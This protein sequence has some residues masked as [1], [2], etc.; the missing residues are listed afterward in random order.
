MDSSTRKFQDL[1]RYRPYLENKI[2]SLKEIR[3]KN[4]FPDEK[5]NQKI[6]RLTTIHGLLCDTQAPKKITLSTWDKFEEIIKKHKQQDR[7]D[8]TC[9][10]LDKLSKGHGES[11]GS[12]SSYGSISSHIDRSKKVFDDTP[13]SPSPPHSPAHSTS[14]HDSAPKVIPLERHSRF[15]PIQPMKIDTVTDFFRNRSPSPA[16]DVLKIVPI[17]RTNMKDIGPLDWDSDDECEV[18]PKPRPPIIVP[19]KPDVVTATKKAMDN[20]TSRDSQR[21]ETSR[22]DEI[23]PIKWDIEPINHSSQNIPTVPVNSLGGSRRLKTV[24]E[25]T[26]ILNLN[27]DLN[28]I[29]SSRH[30]PGLPISDEVMASPNP[31]F[32][33]KPPAPPLHE[34]PPSTFSPPKRDMPAPLTSKVPTTPSLLLNAPMT[35]SKM[36]ISLDDISEFLDDSSLKRSEGMAKHLPTGPR[37]ASRMAHVPNP[38]PGMLSPRS[39]NT[40]LT[41]HPEPRV[42]SD[43]R[44][45]PNSSDPRSYGVSPVINSDPRLASNQGDPRN[46]SVVPS[47]DPRSQSIAGARYA[48]NYERHKRITDSS[49]PPDYQRHQYNQEAI[50]TMVPPP[51]HG[52][53][54]SSAPASLTYGQQM[55]SSN[56]MGYDYWMGAPPQQ[57]QWNQHPRMQQQTTAQPYQMS[58][59]S[60]SWQHMQPHSMIN[61]DSRMGHSYSNQMP[62]NTGRNDS[63][64]QNVMSNNT[65]YGQNRSAGYQD[66]RPSY[67][68]PYEQHQ[69]QIRPSWNNR[70]NDSERFSGRPPFGRPGGPPNSWNKDI[71]R[72]NRDPRMFSDRDPRTRPDPPRPS[73]PPIPPKETP[74][75][76]KASEKDTHPNKS[77]PLPEKEVSKKRPDIGKTD[78]VKEKT[79]E[80]E[81]D[82]IKDKDKHKDKDKD[83]DKHKDK[84]KNKHGEKSKSK[85][86]SS[87]KPQLTDIYGT[88]DAK[89]AVKGSGLQK[90]KIPKKRPS[91]DA[92]DT[93]AAS[94]ENVEESDVLIT[95]D[96]SE[97]QSESSTSKKSSKS[98]AKEKTSKKDKHKNDVLDELTDIDKIDGLKELAAA[99]NLSSEDMAIIF[100]QMMT[101]LKKK[102]KPAIYLSDDE[103]EDSSDKQ[104]SET[105]KTSKKK[106]HSKKVIESSDESENEKK[107]EKNKE[108]KKK[109]TGAL[110]KIISDESEAEEKDNAGENEE[111]FADLLMENDVPNDDGND[112]PVTEQEPESEVVA[113][114]GEEEAATVATE[115]EKIVQ[116]PAKPKPKRRT[117]EL[118]ALQEDLKSSWICDGAMRATGSRMCSQRNK[119]LEQVQEKSTEDQPGISAATAKNIGKMKK[120]LPPKVKPGPKSKKAAALAT[121]VAIAASEASLTSCL[122]TSDSEDDDTPLSFRSENINA[123]GKSK[124][125]TSPKTAKKTRAKAVKVQPPPLFDSSSNDSF[126]LDASAVEPST[127]ISLHPETN[128]TEKTAKGRKT[129]KSKKK[130]TTD[131]AAESSSDESLVDTTAKSRESNEELLDNVMAELASNP[132]YSVAKKK[133]TK[134]KKSNWQMGIVSKKKKKK[135]PAAA[136]KS[137][138]VHGSTSDLSVTNENDLAA[139]DGALVSSKKTKNSLE[140]QDNA[141]ESEDPGWNTMSTTQD[142]EE[143]ISRVDPDALIG[144]TQS[145]GKHQCLL[146]RF[147]RKNIVHHYKIQHPKK[148][149]LISRLPAEESTLACEESMRLDLEN[150]DPPPDADIGRYICRFC[151]FMTKGVDI[152]ARESFYEHCTNHTG[153]YRF[154]CQQCNYEAVTKGSIR[155]HFYKECRKLSNMNL[156]EAIIET[157]IPVDNRIYGYI[158][159]HCN[160]L[161]LKKSNVEKHVRLWHT[162]INKDLDVKIMKI[163]MSISVK[164]EDVQIST[165]FVNTAVVKEIEPKIE[166]DPIE[167]SMQEEFQIEGDED[168]SAACD[169]SVPEKVY[170][171]PEDPDLNITLELVEHKPEKSSNLSAFVCPDEV[172]TKKE[173]EI[174]N[175]RKKKMQEIAQNIG[176]K[177]GEKETPKRLS[178]IDK[179]K[180]KIEETAMPIEEIE[181]TVPE[182]IEMDESPSMEES[183]D[184]LSIPEEKIG[185]PTVDAQ[186]E[187][188]K[189]QILE[190]TRPI[191]E[192]PENS[193]V[194]SGEKDDKASN[195]IKDPLAFVDESTGK[196]V[197]SEDDDSDPNVIPPLQYDSESDQSDHEITTPDVSSILQ[198]TNKIGSPSKG[199]MMTTIQRLAAQLQTK[200]PETP[201]LPEPEMVM[202]DV[203]NGASV[204]VKTEQTSP[205]KQDDMAVTSQ[206]TIK[207]EVHAELGSLTAND[208]G[209]KA[210]EEAASKQTA[211]SP[212]TFIRIRRISGDKLSKGGDQ[213]CESN[214]GTDQTMATMKPLDA[215][216]D[217]NFGFRIE[218]VV[219]L[220]PQDG[221]NKFVPNMRQTVETSPPI[222]GLPV[223]KKAPSQYII[224]RADGTSQVLTSSTGEPLKLVPISI[225]SAVRTSAKPSDSYVSIGGQISIK[226]DPKTMTSLSSAAPNAINSPTTTIVTSTGQPIKLVKINPPEQ[227]PV[228][229]KLKSAVVYER[230]LNDDKLVHLFKCMGRDCCFTTS[231]EPIF[232]RHIQMHEIESSSDVSSYTEYRDFHKCAYCYINCKN[233]TDLVQHLETTHIF[234]RYCCKYCFYRAYAYSYVEIHQKSY[235]PIKKIHILVASEELVLAPPPPKRLD[236][237]QI[238]KPYVCVHECNK[239]FFIPEAFMLHLNMHHKNII[240][241]YK[242]HICVV[243]ASNTDALIEH[244]KQH[245]YFKYH[246]LYCAHGAANM[247]ELASH[248]SSAH[249]NQ[250]PQVLERCLPREILK[251]LSAIEQLR[252]RDIEVM[253]RKPED[254]INPKVPIPPLSKTPS[255]I[256]VIPSA[257]IM[258]TKIL[259]P[260]EKLATNS[261][262]GISN[263]RIIS[264]RS[265]NANSTNLLKVGKNVKLALAEIPKLNLDEALLQKNHLSSYNLFYNKKQI[266]ADDSND[267]NNDVVFLEVRTQPS[268]SIKN[269]QEPTAN[270][271]EIKE[272]TSTEDDEDSNKASESEQNCSSN[273]TGT[274][275]STT[276]SKSGEPSTVRFL[277]LDDVKNTGFM[278]CDLFR[279]GV[280]NCQFSVESAEELRA[281]MQQCL[282]CAEEGTDAALYCPHCGPQSKRFVKPSSF[283][284]HIKIHGVKRFGCILCDAKFAL[285]SQA[286]CHLRLKHKYLTSRF[287][288]ADPTNPSTDGVFYIHPVTVDKV[289]GGKK[290]QKTVTEKPTEQEKTSFLPSEIDKLPLPAIFNKAVQCAICSYTNKVRTNIVR[291]LQAH[292]KDESVPTACPVNPVPCLDKKERMFDKMVNLASSS[293]ENGR[294][295]SGGLGPAPK[296]GKPEEDEGLPKFVPEN[297]R[298]VCGVAEC[299]YLSVDE[300]MLRHHLKALHSDE[301]YYRCPHC[302]PPNGQDPGQNIALDKMGVH[303]KMHDCR[304]YKCS[305]CIYHHYHR[306]VVERHLAD[307]HAEKRQFVKVVRELQTDQQIIENQQQQQLLGTASQEIE[308]EDQPDPDGN[309]W[310]CNLCDFKCILKAAIQN[311]AAIEHNERCQFK[312]NGCGFRTISKITF[313]Q[314]MATKHTNDPHVDYTTVYRRIKSL[315]KPEIVEAPVVQ[316]EPFDTTPLWSR[317]MPRIRH[318]RGILFEE[319]EENNETGKPAKRKSAKSLSDDPLKSPETKK[320][321]ALS[322]DD[323]DK[324]RTADGGFGSYGTPIGNQY[325][326]V[327]CNS[328]KS[329]YKQDFRDHMFRDLKYLRWN[330]PNCEYKSVNRAIL[331]KHHNSKHSGLTFNVEPTSPDAQIEDWVAM[332]VKTQ[333]EIMKANKAA[334][335]TAVEDEAEVEVEAE[336]EESGDEDDYLVDSIKI[337][338]EEIEDINIDNVSS[339]VL[340]EAIFCKHCHMKFTKWRGFKRHVQ[341][342]HLKRLKFLC[343]YC[344]RS[345]SSE[346]MI[347]QHVRSRHKNMPEKVV[348]NPNPKT[349]ELSA[350]FWEREYGLFVP[351]RSKKRKRPEDVTVGV[352]EDGQINELPCKKCDFTALNMTGLKNHMRTHETKVKQK[353]TYCTFSSFNLT[354]MRQHWEVN[355]AHLEF[356]VEEAIVTSAAMDVAALRV[357]KKAKF[358]DEKKSIVYYCYYCSM[359]SQSLDKIRHHWQLLHKDNTRTSM[360]KYKEHSEVKIKCAYCAENGTKSTLVHHIREKHGRDKPLLMVERE[361][362]GWMCDECKEFL[363]NKEEIDEHNNRVHPEYTINVKLVRRS[364]VC[365]QCG[366][367]TISADTMMRHAKSHLNAYRCKYCVEMFKSFHA[368]KNH[369]AVAHVDKEPETRTLTTDEQNRVIENLMRDSVVISPIQLSPVKVTNTPIKS[370]PTSPRLA[371]KSTTKQCVRRIWPTPDK[372]KAVARKS[373][374][375]LPRYPSGIVFEIGERPEPNPISYYGRPISPIDLSKFN[376][377]LNNAGL[378]IKLD[379]AKFAEFSNINFNPRLELVDCVKSITRS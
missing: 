89:K 270:T 53:G 44:S 375:P 128:P 347:L 67:N 241:G 143:V 254:D 365:K 307:K 231:T 295:G 171:P 32:F 359:S 237:K 249:Y 71:Q 377:T 283:I 2:A 313:D 94:E 188:S 162:R 219:S 353:C 95:H 4:T 14:S 7:Y 335:N 306:H 191:K 15:V 78:V 194:V 31:D 248:L 207:T 300:L 210:T 145:E 92:R 80:K 268:D 277:T 149:V 221:V 317:H 175:E 368:V 50:P 242:C 181:T 172:A 216:D 133:Q 224:K 308:D 228:A 321:R 289:K 165:N 63:H 179:L 151:N 131:T 125:D 164:R 6:E 190:E 79:K 13:A 252:V 266:G 334:A 371:K 23:K 262:G 274:D 57:Q 265:L 336:A 138:D 209:L 87:N 36:P 82:K 122:G 263:F 126:N 367:D 117:R 75:P 258:A 223:L 275:H 118:D 196:T 166:N 376:T 331:L 12:G 158:C 185:I 104:K 121:A 16:L 5:I 197:V 303:L 350:E 245:G 366:A 227:M 93:A 34:P 343:A 33:Q 150:N 362:D 319:E 30:Y 286:T 357:G 129:T 323:I 333:G 292:L 45:R 96:T 136:A 327:I 288:P 130:A 46:H 97:K 304:L 204:K 316:D 374:N 290:G 378:T 106:K 101:T 226:L 329:R 29:L 264:A 247:K 193:T 139:S 202:T 110:R 338:E 318:I 100:N 176:I 157:T 349:S 156:N 62:P 116:A 8:K 372:I 243:L 120:P 1:Q 203:G 68:M 108:K 142:E 301:V 297:R 113:A 27:S 86:K 70:V 355:H 178:I 3:F 73:T 41:P 311:H 206:T 251:N 184:P 169:V 369:F 72:P 28:R 43:P 246:C 99:K 261:D 40:I 141:D 370:P 180:D 312:C 177:V 47:S 105:K 259:S 90:F 356:K 61:G 140:L 250:P 235:H 280:E 200:P 260:K 315:K 379:C 332:V 337:E 340:S 341:L 11:Q 132:K 123:D 236:R 324:L 238:I 361:E 81:K 153:E 18:A 52:P 66:S 22:K 84:D 76:F 65:S 55:G 186:T 232:F 103:D 346:V 124:K 253:Q 214:N 348:E 134:K 154:M 325:T 326:C 222:A 287:V 233:Y 205:K 161:Q 183:Q 10:Q 363:A 302:P 309:T 234:C 21:R 364:F 163:D 273:A 168:G 213:E 119:D 109:K 220:A 351:K 54:P 69:P 271:L 284:D 320:Q 114:E 314:H 279:C 9:Q 115:E 218:S 272:E 225:P 51:V 344:D 26:N 239:Y 192:D 56:Q 299:N 182:K 240:S 155:T 267:D 49:M 144:Y 215:E 35:T 159:T 20:L 152:V 358:N 230:M 37:P 352:T 64:M 278:G 339:E 298:Y 25:K 173:E 24:I 354:E 201:P 255:A 256:S 60:T 285:Q 187:E 305:H 146:C 39:D 111:T 211:Q 269:L 98:G 77:K 107:L 199:R 147:Y 170:F 48:D 345:S 195:K 83:K 148:E 58:N 360:F 291:H 310:K 112:L 217:S 19:S 59:Q 281:H 198:D 160:F 212:K 282:P 276:T 373:T 294:M 296:E 167:T 88:I 189:P 85:S 330:C 208:N 74:A 257:P 102:K 17:P 38:S 127:D 137:D 229:I 293:H 42:Q 328:Y 91:Y 174:Q 322:I 244:Y 342:K 135:T